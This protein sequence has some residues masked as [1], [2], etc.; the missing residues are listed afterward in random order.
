MRSLP[1]Y[2]YCTTMSATFEVALLTLHVIFLG[3]V[4]DLLGNM[5]QIA[6]VG[7]LLPEKVETA[8]AEGG[9]PLTWLAAMACDC[10]ND[11]CAIF[12]SGDELVEKLV[13]E[14]LVC[15]L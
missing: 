15:R 11:C 1:R 2:L 3:R 12:C 7:V 5:D 14:G 8:G 9:R 4:F 13:D 6:V 10:I